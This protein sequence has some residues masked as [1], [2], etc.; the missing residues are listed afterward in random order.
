MDMPQEST[1]RRG[2]KP[3]IATAARHTRDLKK[4]VKVLARELEEL[5]SRLSVLDKFYRSRERL[6]TQARR[7]GG[8]GG[9]M[10]G[11]GPNVR[12]VALEILKKGGEPMNI[13]TLASHVIRRKGGRAGANFTQNLGAAL[14]RDRRFKRTGRGLYSAR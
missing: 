12:D 14:Y 11:R 8:G 5:E 2:R 6:L 4:S 9:G 7:G 13:A 3:S 1:T 10:R